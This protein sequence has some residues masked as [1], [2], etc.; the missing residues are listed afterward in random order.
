MADRICTVCLQTLPIDKFYEH[1]RKGYMRAACI[2][3][4][5]QKKK[6]YYEENKEKYN[7]QIVEY[8]MKKVKR[9]PNF[10]LLK[11]MRCRVYH[12]LRNQSL[13]K[14]RRTIEYLGCTADFFCRW[15][16]F[17]LY[18]GMTLKNYGDVWH[19]DHVKPISTFDLTIKEEIEKCFSW[20]NCRP[21][22][23]S[24][25]ISKSD[26]YTPFDSVLQE[27][28]ACVFQKRQPATA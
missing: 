9:D 3:C 19:V 18:D 12:A 28:K 27:I 7:K 25:N 6:E 5:K 14:N 4:T 23:A 26:N 17:Q 1:K 20:M 13:N 22:L 2:E 15:I 8:Q 10:H 24:K 11:L 21:S 16:E